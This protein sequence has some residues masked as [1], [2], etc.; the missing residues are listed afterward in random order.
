VIEEVR[1]L[2]DITQSKESLKRQ[3]ISAQGA[4]HKSSSIIHS[5][6]STSAQV[7]FKSATVTVD[8]TNL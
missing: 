1:K 5:E 8:Q 3:I 2:T 7:S 6:S 4:F